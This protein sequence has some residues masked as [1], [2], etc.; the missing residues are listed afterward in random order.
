MYHLSVS[1]IDRHM[2][3][4]ASITIEEQIS[5]CASDAEML[6]PQPVCEPEECGSETP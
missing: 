3:D 5:G 6:V 4:P 2:I 1:N